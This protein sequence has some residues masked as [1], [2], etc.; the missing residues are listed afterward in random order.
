MNIIE[1]NAHCANSASAAWPRCSKPVYIR[2]KPNRWRP[3]I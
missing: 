3:S 2:R 1:L